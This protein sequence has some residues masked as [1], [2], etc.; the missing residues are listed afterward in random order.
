MQEI[1][2]TTDGLSVLTPVSCALEASDLELIRYSSCLLLPAPLPFV[3]LNDVEYV[4]GCEDGFNF[5]Y[6]FSEACESLSALK[7]HILQELFPGPSDDASLALRVGSVH[8]FL[9]FLAFIDRA[10]ALQG[11]GFL[12]CLVEHLARL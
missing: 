8:G 6:E 2:L 5:F 7:A 12:T 3:L 11:L 9:S 1:A 10:L 4:Q